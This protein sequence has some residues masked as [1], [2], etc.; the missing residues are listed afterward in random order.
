MKVSNYSTSLPRK[1]ES[2]GHSLDS[3]EKVSCVREKEETHGEIGVR[4][5]VERCC[6]MERGQETRPREGE[7]VKRGSERVKRERRKRR[8][9]A[10]KKKRRGYIGLS[11][12]EGS[13][14]PLSLSH[15]PSLSLSP[16]AVGFPFRSSSLRCV[17]M[18]M[19]V[20]GTRVRGYANRMIDTLAGW[21]PSHL[22]FY[23][24]R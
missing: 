8:R 18:F 21:L 10:T 3:L 5:G 17:R 16:L 20:Q 24:V 13:C 14:L 9:G 19:R 12:R 23:S 7:K 1:G 11:I 4:K 22:I 6:E 15:S 2:E